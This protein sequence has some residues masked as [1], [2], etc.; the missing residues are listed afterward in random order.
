MEPIVISRIFNAPRELVWKAW[1]D[2]EM[3]KQWWGPEGFTAPSAKVDLRVGGEVYLCHAR[4]SRNN[5]EQGHVY[6][7][8]F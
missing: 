4:S 7:W 5:L 1:T 2:P 8:C 6:R 3:I